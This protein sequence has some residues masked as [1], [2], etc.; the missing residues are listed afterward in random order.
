MPASR[1]VRPRRASCRLRREPRSLKRRSPKVSPAVQAH[2]HAT[3]PLSKRGPR[4]RARC[5]SS[6]DRS[7]VPSRLLAA[8]VPRLSSHA[9]RR[10]RSNCDPCALHP[11]NIYQPARTVAPRRRCRRPGCADSRRP[12]PP[13]HEGIAPSPLRCGY[14]RA[15]GAADIGGR[16]MRVAARRPIQSSPYRS[17]RRFLATPQFARTPPV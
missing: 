11:R 13:S 2:A 3:N 16:A 6:S 14:P 1:P 8:P 15:T 5:G 4:A 9:A 17:R 10:G 7:L 12:L